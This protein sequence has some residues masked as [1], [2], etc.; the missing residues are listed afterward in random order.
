MLT[1]SKLTS[2]K[3]AYEHFQENITLENSRFVVGMPFKSDIPHLGD[4]FV[5][6]KNIFSFG[7]RLI[8]S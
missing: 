5:Q 4:T 8:L 1:A 3:L 2:E 7:L 6:A